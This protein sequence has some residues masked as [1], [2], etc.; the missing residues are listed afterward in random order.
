LAQFH[1]TADARARQLWR[2]AA[3]LATTPE[4]RNHTKQ[5]VAMPPGH[6]GSHGSGNLAS[7]GIV[8]IANHNNPDLDLIMMKQF[9]V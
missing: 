9:L 5:G 4:P 1:C 3:C 8:E 7:T 2:Q 6:S